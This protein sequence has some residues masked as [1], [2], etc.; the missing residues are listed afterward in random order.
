MQWA[1]ALAVA[2]FECILQ[3]T[4]LRINY[5]V[6]ESFLVKY[7]MEHKS[8]NKLQNVQTSPMFK[9]Y[10]NLHFSI[11]FPNKI[12]TVQKYIEQGIT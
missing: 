1:M 6:A 3:N 2:M 10:K 9:L 4:T 8:R 11:Q 12:Q 7:L 5:S